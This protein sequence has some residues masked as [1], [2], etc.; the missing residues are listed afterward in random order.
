[1]NNADPPS[2]ALPLPPPPD[3]LFAP[4]AADT[5][6]PN[7]TVGE[8]LAYTAEMKAREGEAPAARRARVDAAVSQLG[9]EACRDVL[10]GGPAARGLSG[11]QL[12]R[13]NIGL[14]LV[15]SPKVLFLDEPT[16]GLDSYT[17]NEVMTVVRSLAD[18]GIT[19]LAT[20]HS[21]SP[22]AFSRFHRLFVMLAGRCVYFGPNDDGVAAALGAGAEAPAAESRLSRVEWLTDVVVAADRAGRAAE[23]AA[24]Y[25]RS[26]LA[27]TNAEEAAALAASDPAAAGDRASALTQVRRAT[28]RGAAAG[29]MALLRHRTRADLRDP[30]YL[31]P[32]IAEKALTAFVVLTLYVG[33]GRDGQAT[34][35]T[36]VVSALFMWCTLPGFSAVAYTPAIVLERPLYNRERSD[37]LYA[38]L[39]YLAFKL[40]GEVVVAAAVAPLL[41]AAVWFAVGF[42]GSFAVFWATYLLTTVTGIALGYAV[43]ALSRDLLTANTALPAF[44]VCMLFF[45]GLL[46]RYDDMPRYLAWM[47]YADFLHYAWGAVTLNQ[48][49]GY[50]DPAAAVVVGSEQVLALYS[51]PGALGGGPW[52][53]IAVESIFLV[54][55]LAI[56]W[57]AL[58]FVQHAKR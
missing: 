43:A 14:A 34:S 5:L 46:M 16:T 22:Y 48:Y 13:A 50:D 12:K 44:V 9:L 56:A 49:L 32:R 38:P 52:R 51:L 2:P 58:A 11:G 37:G 29:Y 21:P 17:A 33:V 10:V 20:L 40:T 45:T 1:M 3:A 26:P 36:G 35:N 54:G 41:A 31:A 55:F 47:M 23:L 19:V 28:E 24:R 6:V 57:A 15:A 7:M 4:R 42:Q 30:G 53:Y 39:T 27:A 18:A 25:A 8:V